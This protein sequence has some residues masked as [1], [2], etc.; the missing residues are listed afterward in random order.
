[1]KYYFLL[2]CFLSSISNAKESIDQKLQSYVDLFQLK[3]VTAPTKLNPKLFALGRSLFF[4]KNISGNKNISCADCHHP[5]IGTIDKLPLSV[6]EGA[7]GLE[8]TNGGRQQFSG[9]LLARNAPAL[10][11][12]HN[13]PTMFWDGRVQLNFATGN[14]VTPAALPIEFK[15]V[16]SNALSVQALFP[17]VNHDEMRG[18]PGSNEI[19]NAATEVEAW[20]SILA[21]ILSNPSYAQEFSEIFPGE[22][23]SLAHAAEAI[24]H[25]E[26][27]AFFSADTNYDRYL[28]GD[29][30]AMTEIQKM[31]MDIFFG[32]GKCGQCHYGE[33]LSDFSFHN[34]GIPQ[35][36]PGKINGDDFGRLE[37]DPRDDFKYAFKVP[38][39]RN[40][41]LT[42]PYMHNGSFKTIAQ[43]IEHYDDIEAS[44]ESYQLVNNYTNYNEEIV[45]PLSDTNADKINHL[46]KVLTRKLDFLE[47]EE[48]AL[49]EFI[50]GALTDNRFLNQEINENYISSIRIQL[51]ES[52]Y[53]KLKELIPSDNTRQKSQYLY[54]DIYNREE[55]YRLRELEKPIKL[56]FILNDQN[57]LNYRKQLFKTS[58]SQEGIVASGTFED[59]EILPLSVEES[60]SMKQVNQDFF[61]RLYTYKNQTTSADI[62]MIEKEV[63]KNDVLTMNSLI[64]TLPLE[65]IVSLSDLLG[66]P[67]KDLFFAPTSSNTKEEFRWIELVEGK[68]LSTVLQK[69]T[70]RTQ[71]GGIVTTWSIEL[72]FKKMSKKDFSKTL[73]SWLSKLKS[74]G[75]VPADAQGT[76]PSPSKL[77]EEILKEI[78]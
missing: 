24:G 13:V 11:N 18:Q 53:L 1:M 52:G 38:G 35:I 22:T 75:F 26:A 19:A 6:G 32:K 57:T 8:N 49:A 16:L 76:S 20:T 30:K 70:I 51:N 63:M 9:K 64:K 71:V 36:G 73:L 58:E 65:N 23:I 40:V 33:H 14:F 54:F 44:L 69:S 62:P 43:V 17:M 37:Q 27:Q 59:E 61:Q 2:L 10:F 15:K 60:E 68:N 7:R 46:S 41:S 3:T 67:T 74:S 39:L 55:G 72:N 48:K 5:S 31:G 45:G 4:E 29:L 56:Y 12:L 66:I 77:T 50:N 34:I 42:A 78:F 25:F 28:K 47:T 21:R